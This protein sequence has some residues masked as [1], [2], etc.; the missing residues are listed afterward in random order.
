MFV[1]VH[2]GGLQVSSVEFVRN[3]ETER[4]ELS[5]LL[6]NRVEEAGGEDERSPFVVGLHLFQEVLVDHCGEGSE[7]TGLQTLGWLSSH[8]NCNLQQTERK[9]LV[10]LAS[11]PETEVFVDFLVLGEQDFFHLGHEFETQ[12]TIV[13]HHPVTCNES[14]LDHFKSR[15]LH[16]FSHGD[17]SSGELLLFLCE[18]IN[19]VGGISS[20]GE[21][22]ED[23]FIWHTFFPHLLDL[24]SDWVHEFVSQHLPNEL[25]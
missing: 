21:Q 12:M 16:F 4:T 13:E 7:E 3:A 17:L 14:S 23:W 19:V 25:G 10:R 11:D 5:S 8:L 18:L 1:N 6:D 15:L 22:V 9:L 20:S 2:H 24:I